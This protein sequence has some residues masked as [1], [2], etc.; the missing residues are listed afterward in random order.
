MLP[1]DA[2]AVV[3]GVEEYQVGRD[4]RLDD[5]ALD[6]CRFVRWLTAY[7]VLADRITLLVSRFRRTPTRWKSSRGATE[8]GRPPTTRRLTCDREP[9]PLP[10]GHS[11]TAEGDWPA[12]RRSAR[13]NKPK[14]APVRSAYSA[15]LN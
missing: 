2:M 11:L 14:K 13:H 8:S 4:W 15:R 1:T 10:D 3:V 6:A 7:G 12:T 9:E 5:P